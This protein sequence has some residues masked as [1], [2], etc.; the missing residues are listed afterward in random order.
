MALKYTA[1][2]RNLYLGMTDNIGA[3]WVDVFQGDTEFYST[4]Y[5]DLLTNIWCQDEAVCKTDALQF[6]T[7]LKSAHT[8][9]KYIKSALQR[10]FLLES[11]P[12]PRDA[13]SKLL[14]FSTGARASLDQFIDLAVDDVQ[15]MSAAPL[16]QSD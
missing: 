11:D 7:R 3:N 8:A 10:G 12:P 15:Q 1:A 2:Q 14:T 5:W 13:R 9:G 4:A 6:M 16:H